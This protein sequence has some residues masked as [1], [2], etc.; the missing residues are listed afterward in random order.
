M[1]QLELDEGF[2]E[3]FQFLPSELAPT[4]PV[5]Y[6]HQRVL[7]FGVQVD[8][9]AKT[10]ELVQAHGGS[11]VFPPRGL[12]GATVSYC[13]DPDGNVMELADRTMA[14]IVSAVAARERA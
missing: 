13:R 10:L 14:A 7:H 11:T 12:A 1:C 6:T 4:E 3:L 5:P 8:D 2:I 9:V